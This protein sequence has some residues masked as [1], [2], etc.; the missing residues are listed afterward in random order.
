MGISYHINFEKILNHYSLINIRYSEKRNNVK[1][2]IEYR[3]LIN[4]L[5]SENLGTRIT[6]KNADNRKKMK[7]VIQF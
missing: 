6:R 5:R 7:L 1:Q 4:D 2:N 3:T